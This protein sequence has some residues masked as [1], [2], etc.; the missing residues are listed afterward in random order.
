MV[1]IYKGFINE[2]AHISYLVLPGFI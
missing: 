1:N 2:S